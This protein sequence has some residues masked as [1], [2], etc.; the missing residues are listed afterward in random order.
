MSHKDD[1]EEVVRLEKLND[2]FK[3]SL[4]R[5][6]EMLH[7]SEVRLAANSN[8]QDLGQLEAERNKDWATP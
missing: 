7:A 1:N 5:C 8:E 6:R 4:R 2:D 3:K